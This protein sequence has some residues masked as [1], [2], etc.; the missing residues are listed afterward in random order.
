MIL[1]AEG[2]CSGSEK[3]S[4]GKLFFKEK[5]GKFCLNWWKSKHILLFQGNPEEVTKYEDLLDKLMY[6][7]NVSNK[8]KHGGTKPRPKTKSTKSVIIKV[9]HSSADNTA[10]FVEADEDDTEETV[11]IAGD[12]ILKGQ[13]EWLMSRQKNLQCKAFSR[14][15]CSDM[16]HYLNP[17]ISRKP[18]YLFLHVGTND[19]QNYS[20]DEVANMIRN[21]AIKVRNNNIN[22]HVSS[23]IMRVDKPD[24]NEKVKMV[25]SNLRTC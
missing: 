9:T 5:Y 18:D 12:S 11:V 14:S 2:D 3:K 8:K 23:L 15:T 1:K 7:G 21:L 13:K 4:T 22:C 24:L 25:N 20:P 17:M 16:D 10:E 6:G 19:L